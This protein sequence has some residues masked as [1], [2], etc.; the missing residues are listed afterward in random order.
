MGLGVGTMHYTGMAAMQLN[1]QMVYDPVWFTG[2]IVIAYALATTS[3]YLWFRLRSSLILRPWIVE[4]L[5]AMVLG[6]AISAMHY[7]GMAAV[8]YY[9]SEAETMLTG[10]DP[11]GLAIPI[12][13]ATTFIIA[14]LMRS[15]GLHHQLFTARMTIERLSEMSPDSL[16]TIDSSA[17]IR[18]VN[19]QTET[20]FG[21]RRDELI[22]HPVQMLIPQEFHPAFEEAL[23][24]FR[25]NPQQSNRSV[26]IPVRGL[27]KDGREILT[28]I[29]INYEITGGELFIIASIRDITERKKAERE[30][31]M[32][33]NQLLQ[34]Q[35]M[36]AVGRLAGGIAHDFNNILAGIG[37]YAELVKSSL[38]QSDPNRQDLDAIEDLVKRAA[39]LTNQLMTFSKHGRVESEVFDLRD[40]AKR[41]DSLVRQLIRREI[42]LEIDAG[43]EPVFVEGSPGQVEQLLMNLVINSADAIEGKG[44]IFIVVQALDIAADLAARLAVEPGPWASLRVEDTGHGIPEDIRAYIFEPFY[45]TRQLGKGSGLGLSVVF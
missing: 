42:D 11:S 9:P 23:A 16:I 34:A 4:G 33:E 8:H 27:H 13:L 40:Q 39:R 36:E 18:H 1:G 43:T 5:C 17:K 41:V 7:T 3:F 37:G 15:L 35:K 30:R 12:L 32:L 38:S 31:K 19:R 10:I 6:G 44:T 21:Y 26:E 24:A 28:E 2:S 14:M 22:G 29:I 45:S 25:A 20:T